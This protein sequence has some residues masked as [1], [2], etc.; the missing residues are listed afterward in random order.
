MTQTCPTIAVNFWHDMSYGCRFVYWLFVAK[1][2]K[3]LRHQLE[4]EGEKEEA[5][6]PSQ[7]HP[8][9]KST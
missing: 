7:A 8:T 6:P 5:V 3:A 1:A 9:N 2:G 4:E